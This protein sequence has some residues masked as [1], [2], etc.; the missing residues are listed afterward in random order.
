[1]TRRPRR[2]S[3]EGVVGQRRD[4]P[5]P[6]VGQR[7]HG[8]GICARRDAPRGRRPRGSGR[9]GRC[10]AR[11]ADPAP[12]R[13][14][15][16]GPSSPAWATVRS[17]RPGRGEHRDEVDGG[18]PSSAESRPTAWSRSGGQRG[19][20]RGHRR[21]PEVAEEAEDQPGRDP[22]VPGTASVGEPWSTARR[23]GRRGRCG[24]GGRRT[25]RRGARRRPGR[26]RGS[27]GAGRR[28]PPRCAAL[29]GRVVDVEERLQVGEHVRGTERLDVGVGERHVVRAAS[30]K[31]SSG[32]SVPSRWR[33]SS[34]FGT[35]DDLRTG[36]GHGDGCLSGRVA[37]S[38]ELMALTSLS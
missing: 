38:G 11:G 33:C 21:R 37:G 35:G 25:P 32:S 2:A 3:S 24:S 9:R 15:T 29:T 18:W 16:G 10:A 23:R 19:V 17:P 22:R 30:S 1:M 12:P 4:D 7:A 5:Q 27:G 13:R 20:Q 34:A 26:G 28:S 36:D 14:R 6:D 31:S 8:E